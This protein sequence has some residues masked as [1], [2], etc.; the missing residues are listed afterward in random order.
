MR[1]TTLVAI[2]EREVGPSGSARATLAELLAERGLDDEA[3]A[4]ERIA[5]ARGER[6][7]AG[8]RESG[9]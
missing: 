2:L 3:A 1:L 8:R 6:S 4:Q 7:R 9:H 5:R